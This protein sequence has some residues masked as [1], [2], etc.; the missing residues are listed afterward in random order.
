MSAERL[1]AAS[2]PA[3]HAATDASK[4]CRKLRNVARG[5][6]VSTGRNRARAISA[7][8]ARASG[9]NMIEATATPRT[10]TRVN[11]KPSI[12]VVP[13][14]HTMSLSQAAIEGLV[15]R[16]IRQ[17]TWHHQHGQRAVFELPRGRGAVVIGK[18]AQQI[19]VRAPRPLPDW[20]PRP[21]GSFPPKPVR[22]RLFYGSTEAPDE[23]SDL[24]RGLF[25]F[26][27]AESRSEHEVEKKALPASRGRGQPRRTRAEWAADAAH[28][29]ERRRRCHRVGPD[30]L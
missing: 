7:S 8:C 10:R 23:P 14:R 18:R 16:S 15:A 21:T 20:K 5:L 24:K 26:C 27:A 19:G 6:E 3:R 2:S 30:D 11:R 17:S 12:K 13:T 29:G 9:V 1:R 25:A 22:K 4:W 28:R